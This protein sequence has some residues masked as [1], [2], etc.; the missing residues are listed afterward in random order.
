ML[1]RCDVTIVDKMDQFFL[2]AE[3]VDNIAPSD[4]N[5]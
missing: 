3:S 4:L 1:C 5:S 2:R